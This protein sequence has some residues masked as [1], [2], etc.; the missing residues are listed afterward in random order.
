MTDVSRQQRRKEA[1]EQGKLGSR[2][3]GAGLPMEPKRD[4]VLAVARVVATKFAEPSNTARASEAA[5]LAHTLCEASLRARPSGAT[6]ACREGCSYCCHQFV[7]AVAPE[8]FLLASAL[9][10]NRDPRLDASAVI[11]RCAPLKGLAAKDRVGLKLPCPVLV[12]GRCGAYAARPLVCR[13][14]TSLD[15]DGCIEE[16]EGRNMEAQIEVSSAHLA[17]AGTAHVVLLGALRSAGLSDTAFELSDALEIAL[18]DATSERRW[19][20]GEP[21]FGALT[22][23]VPVPP[24]VNFVAQQI[25]EALA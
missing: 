15:L 6:I 7:G 14:I 16:F 3:L 4:D 24:R 5:A 22:C 1:R 11:D 20:A 21:V 18:S 25:A 12:E 2:L 19:L 10:A 8:V 9:R 17:H 13:Q 23:S